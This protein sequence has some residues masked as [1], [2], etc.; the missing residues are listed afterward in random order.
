MN[1]ISVALRALVSLSLLGILLFS[2]DFSQFAELLRNVNGF[3]FVSYLLFGLVTTL[4]S[5]IK[6]DILCNVFGIKA[7][8]LK[9]FAY[10]FIGYFYNNFLPTSVGGDVV[11][12]LALSR[13]AKSKTDAFATVFVERYTGLLTLVLFVI[14]VTI[15]DV[16]LYGNFSVLF[17]S[18]SLVFCFLLGSLFVF[19]PFFLTK[20]EEIISWK[21]F[22][23]ITRR[24]KS[25][26]ESIYCYRESR[27]T[28]A[29]AMFWS[30]LYYFSTIIYTYIGLKAF[31]VDVAFSD[32]LL[33]VPIMLMI[34]LLPISLG[35]IG[36][37]EWSHAFALSLLG[38]PPLIGVSLGLL[39]RFRTLIYSGIGGVISLCVFRK[40]VVAGKST[41]SV[42]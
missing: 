35:G 13:Y 8:I 21:F 28:L 20:I 9:L 4:L 33:A 18:I 16:R 11:R 7:G 31:N 14:G 39:F 22:H 32:A 34:F 27:K 10:Y 19:H 40:K 25:L 6:W 26:Q 23:K 38:V 2:V 36:L 3:Y 30:I 1:K 17:M 42:L 24:A 41:G 12:S 5:S 29:Y 37:Q 15:S